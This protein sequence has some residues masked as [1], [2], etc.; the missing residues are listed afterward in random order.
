MVAM[1]GEPR[2]KL[3][4]IYQEVLGEVVEVVKRLEAVSA[5][6][7]GVA[8]AKPADR[9]AE[10]IQDAALKA[11]AKVR[12][13]LDQAIADAHQGLSAAASEVAAALHALEAERH[14][15]FWARMNATFCAAVLGGVV[16][17]LMLHV[18]R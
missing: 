16:A 7:D 2:S 14:R 9:V 3:D 12:S 8:T 6:I 1:G 11:I 5:Q 10:V 15:T 4:I 17:G 13:E 18:L